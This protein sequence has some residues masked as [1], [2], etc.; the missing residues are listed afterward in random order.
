LNVLQS[1]GHSFLPRGMGSTATGVEG[2][3]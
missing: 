2:S 1:Q 3:W